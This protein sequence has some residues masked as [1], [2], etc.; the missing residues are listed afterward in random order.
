[1]KTL[2]DFPCGHGERLCGSFTA[3]KEVLTAW[4]PDEVIP[5]L[6]S[7]EE[8]AK[9][10]RWVAGMVAYEAATAFDPAF[11]T[12]PP[13]PGLPLAAFLVFDGIADAAA[14]PDAASRFS[15]TPW[16]Q[17]TS[18]AV[19]ERTV[20]A[21]RNQIA[22]GDFYQTNFTTRLTSD[23]TGDPEAFFD[24]LCAAQPSSYAFYLDFEAWQIAS[25]SPELFFAWDPRTGELETRPMKGTAPSE[26]AV[27][28][29]R[30]SAKDRAENLMIVDLLR[31]DISRVASDVRVSDLFA[32]QALPTAL[33]MTSTVKG[34]TGPEIGLPD[35]FGALFPCGS[36]T[37]A[38]KVAA[39]KAIASYETSPRGAYCGALGIIQPGGHAIFSVGI[40]TVTIHKSKATCGV[41]SGIT[42]D[43]Q[44]REEFAEGRIKQRFLWRG[45][46]AFSLLETFR[47]E[48]GIYWLLQ[49]H[50]DRMQRSASYFGFVFDERCV[51]MALDTV[52][53][54][55]PSGLFRVRLLVDRGGRVATEAFVF[56]EDTAAA[57]SIQFPPPTGSETLVG[58]ARVPVS[59]DDEFLRHK[60]THRA[61]YDAFAPASPNLFDTLLYN[62][63]REITEF[64]RGNLFAKLDGAI[65]TPSESCGLLPGTLRAEL[66]ASGEVSERIITY[67]DLQCATA[68]WFVN[69]L[70]GV[71]PTRLDTG[72][73]YSKSD[74]PATK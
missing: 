68:L 70:R 7:A 6:Q 32:V 48:A 51:R 33:Q 11:R 44:C 15:C 34:T 10:G 59:S 45:S 25:V 69:G 63:R 55:H 14:V 2:I 12:A 49:R 19:F 40:R 53:K 39:M 18:Y 16:K 23:F 46:A 8:R 72:S 30:S 58:L 21:I 47:L 52:A 4:H 60:T 57:K 24:A 65:V 28:A 41:G 31:N 50:I 62:Q 56:A 37:G 67:E 54:T 26:S 29:L 22:A 43:S 42:W 74:G 5:L 64:T 27:E 17:D 13:S 3:P 73:Q 61:V 20:E 1:M 38:P 66:L 35:V 36:V 9:Q 71:I